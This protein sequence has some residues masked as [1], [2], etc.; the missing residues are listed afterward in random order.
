MLKQAEKGD[1][2]DA[3]YHY[4][5]GMAYT[6]TNNSQLANQEFQ[7]TLQIDP[8]YSHADEIRKMLAH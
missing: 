6:K 5:L 2:K 3:N 4:H 7:N 8:H 1:P